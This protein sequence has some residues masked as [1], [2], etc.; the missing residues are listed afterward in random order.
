MRRSRMESHA[1]VPVSAMLGVG[2]VCA[3]LVDELNLRPV[4]SGPD[5]DRIII[6]FRS[7]QTTVGTEVNSFDRRSVTL[8]YSARA[9]RCKSVDENKPVIG[10]G[11]KKACT[12]PAA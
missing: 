3:G 11:G 12:S 9:R 4:L 5:S 6:G 1:S 2:S 10:G 8:K 7:Q